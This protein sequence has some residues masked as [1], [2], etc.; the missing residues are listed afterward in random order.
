MTLD[1]FE[2]RLTVD[3]I[4]EE[5]VACDYGDKVDKHSA[6]FYFKTGSTIKL[7]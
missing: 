5:L 6:D 1:D 4:D 7:I 2:H 3:S